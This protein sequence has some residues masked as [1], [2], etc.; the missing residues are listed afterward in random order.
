MCAAGQVAGC[1]RLHRLLL[2]L[3]LL[4]LEQ[5]HLLLL[6]L[7]FLLGL[8]CCCSEQRQRLAWPQACQIRRPA[9]PAGAI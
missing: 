9:Q 4:L 2:L 3:L 1:V 5:A 8:L 7:L 6:L